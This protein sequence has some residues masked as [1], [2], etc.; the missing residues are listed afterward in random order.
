MPRATSR[1][2]IYRRRRYRPELIEQCV[3]WY[4]TYRLSY[5]DL[6]AM[7][8]ERAV[9]VSHTTIMRWVRHYVPEYERRWS[10]YHRAIKQRSAPM[11]G[12]KSFGSAAVTFSGI[13][14][15]HRI[16]KRQFNVAYEHQ[17]RALSLK[18]LWDKALSGDILPCSL[19]HAPPPLMHQISP[20]RAPPRLRAPQGRDG[21]VRYP[22]RVSLGQCLYLM[23]M[24]KG[25]RYW[26]YR[27]QFEGR[28]KLISLGCYR[29]VPV[30]SDSVRPTAVIGRPV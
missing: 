25:G 13:E 16:R 7:M 24:P 6:S 9:T 23:I 28:E 19:D 14:L 22:R 20:R 12:L 27:Y 10:R 21:V 18:E 11:L 15:A 2:P 3:R 17:G 30:E 29:D 4:L 5:R 1:D 26:H 8:A